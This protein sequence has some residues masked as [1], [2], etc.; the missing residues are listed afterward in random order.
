MGSTVSGMGMRGRPT[1]GQYWR[2][3]PSQGQPFVLELKGWV[4]SYPDARVRWPWGKGSRPVWTC[5]LCPLGCFFMNEDSKV[6]Y[7]KPQKKV[8]T[9]T[10]A[11]L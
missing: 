3:P 11:P 2:F 10:T 1:T 4:M 5:L 8:P 9:A 7:W 6:S